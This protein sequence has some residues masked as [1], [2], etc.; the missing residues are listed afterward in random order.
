MSVERPL[1]TSRAAAMDASPDRRLVNTMLRGLYADARSI[2]TIVM[3][4]I[5]TNSSDVRRPGPA[6]DVVHSYDP[7]TSIPVHIHSSTTHYDHDYDPATHV[8]VTVSTP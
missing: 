7:F 5:V 3:K 2:R 1:L 6:L 4:N 8:E